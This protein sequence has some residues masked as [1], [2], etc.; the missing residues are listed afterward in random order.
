MD[1]SVFLSMVDD[2]DEHAVRS[3]ALETNYLATDVVESAS[4]IAKL[5]LMRWPDR[6]QSEVDF[7]NRTNSLYEQW[8]DTCRRLGKAGRAYT[9]ISWITSVRGDYVNYP[10]FLFNRNMWQCKKVLRFFL[11]DKEHPPYLAILFFNLFRQALGISHTELHHMSRGAFAEF[12]PLYKRLMTTDAVWDWAANRK[13]S[14]H[15]YG[16]QTNTILGGY[17]LVFNNKDVGMEF[18]NREAEARFDI[19]GGFNTSEIERLTQCRFTC[20]DVRSPYLRDYDDDLVMRIAGAANRLW[21]ADDD[22]RHAFLERQDRVAWHPFDVYTDSFPDAS[23]Y[24]FVSTGFMTSTVRPSKVEARAKLRHSGLGGVS[25]SFHGLMRVME[26]VAQGKDV[27][28]FTLQRAS[29]R[30]Y[31]YKT[32]L[33]QWRGGR[34]TRLMTT[35]DIKHYVRWGKGGLDVTYAAINPE[36]R[37]YLHLLGEDA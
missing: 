12:T 2:H 32:V 21:I 17:D 6:E 11:K 31:K 5:L 34:L 36:N 27:D 8:I 4:R 18:F 14:F 20:A 3:G 15:F 29:G 22:T 13:Q 1:P 9:L 24:A 37:Y 35:D 26:K 33:L 7:P 16:G 25:T 23:S 28:L 19:G 10:I 30:V